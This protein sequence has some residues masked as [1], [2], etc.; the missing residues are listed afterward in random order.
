[1]NPCIESEESWAY[2]KVTW[3]DLSF[4]PSDEA[5]A[6][7]YEAWAWFLPQPF[8]PVVVSTLGDIFF[9]QGTEA[10]FWLNTGTAEITQVAESRPHFLELL[11]GEDY[12]NW[13]LPNLIGKL[14]EAG[15]QL[16]PD[17]CYTYVTLPIFNE[18]T[19]EVSNLNPVPASEHFGV[20]GSLHHQL[21]GL[22]DGAR[23]KLTVV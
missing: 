3:K 23:I 5:L 14:K 20:T 2:M 7:L 17:Y 4:L 6:E 12:D 22:P 11:K 18:G 19:F 15:K 9:Q 21:Q 16:K 1:M 13:F 8:E 10:V